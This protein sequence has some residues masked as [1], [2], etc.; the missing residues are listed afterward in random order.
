MLGCYKRIRYKLHSLTVRGC[1]ALAFDWDRRFE[2]ASEK[3]RDLARKRISGEI[4]ARDFNREMGSLSA[5]EL[6][7]LT[8][9]LLKAPLHGNEEDPE[10]SEGPLFERT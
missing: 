3:V 1:A 6:G 5:D 10:D 9:L 8:E 2:I 4:G 7:Q